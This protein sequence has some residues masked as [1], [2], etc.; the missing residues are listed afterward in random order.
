MRACKLGI[1]CPSFCNKF[2]LFIMVIWGL[3]KTYISTYKSNFLGKGEEKE[4]G[5]KKNERRER[6][7]DRTE[8][9]TEEYKEYPI[10]RLIFILAFLCF[11]FEIYYSG[12]VLTFKIRK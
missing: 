8:R 4:G 3:Q 11:F 5:K 12:H 1:L 9:S 7:R 10:S 2:R 6:D